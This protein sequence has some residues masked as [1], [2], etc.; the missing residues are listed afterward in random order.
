MKTFNRSRIL[1]R[2]W[3][4]VRNEGLDFSTAQKKAWQA[5]EIENLLRSGDVSFSYTKVVDKKTGEIETRVATGRALS[6]SIPT[7]EGRVTNAVVYYD[8]GPFQTRVAWN[9]R[10]D[11]LAG[12]SQNPTNPFYRDEYWQIDASA[13]YEFDMGLTV[14]AEAINLTG[15]DLKG[16]RR[17]QNNTFFAYRGAPRYAAG[18]RF[19]F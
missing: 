4:I 5:Q 16:Y 11:F 10:D 14:F 3:S 19:S 1:K 17:S 8:K 12:Y 7:G 9:W 18:V 13:S 15:E 6:Q 2:A